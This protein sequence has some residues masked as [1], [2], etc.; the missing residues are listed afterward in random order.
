MQ[1]SDE[2]TR[3]EVLDRLRAKEKD[4]L[5]L[6]EIDGRC[7][8][9]AI[10]N[11]P[12]ISSQ[13]HHTKINSALAWDH[14]TGANL[15]VGI[16]DT[17]VDASHPD[18][19]AHMVP[20]WNFYDNTSDTSDVHGH[21]TKVAGT[22]AAIGN[23]AL[24][25]A[26]LAWDAKIMP[27]RVSDASGYAYYSTISNAITYAADRGAKTVNVSFGGVCQSSTIASAGNY[28]RNKN[29]WVVVGADNTGGDPGCASVPDLLFASAT[30]S[31]DA[32]ASFSSY[33]NHVDIAAPGVS[34]L[35]TTRG[36]GTG[37][38]S[39]TSFSSPVTAGVVTL[40]WSANPTLTSD[41]VEDILFRSAKD[42]GAAGWDPYFGWGRVD[43]GAA[44]ALAKSTSGPTLDTTAPSAPTNLT[45]SAPESTKVNLSWGASVDDVGV[46]GYQVFRGS[47]LLGTTTATTYTDTTVTG[48][49]T[50]SYTT[51]GYDAA[52]NVSLASNVA[53][54]T[55]PQAPF[56][57]TSYAVTSKTSSTA[58]ITWTSNTPSTGAVWYGLTGR[59]GKTTTLS[60]SATDSISATTHT[61]VLSGLTRATSYSYQVRA[62]SSTGEIANSTTST[63]KTTR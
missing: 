14:A 29:G 50:Y 31:N 60:L 24:Q 5:E 46:T 53:T 34:I 56:S 51:K 20:G 40:I 21:G 9:I 62:Q 42:L 32:K 30:D 55:T 52:N 13:W 23:N 2:D 6:M 18:L 3:E 48:S 33:G 27:L 19:A 59:K 57:I 22:Q 11:D 61:V 43:A 25:V 1:V 38:V 54:V 58:T 63:F 10:L 28:M 15:T 8:P 49:T 7:E 45:A 44:V 37:S 36:G 16:A 35:T 4:K 41:Q 39:G 12:S 17:G 26:G 47:A